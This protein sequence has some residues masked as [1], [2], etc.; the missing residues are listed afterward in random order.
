MAEILYRETA[1]GPIPNT[2]SVKNAMLTN[3]EMDGNIRSIVNDLSNKV[4]I[5]VLNA[6][7]QTATDAAV[8]MA[9][10]LG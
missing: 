2:T 8:A 6:G 1:T 3:I 10:A 5:N 4:G 7:I 9:I